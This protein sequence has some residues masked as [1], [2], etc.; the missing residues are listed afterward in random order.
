MFVADRKIK[1]CA[2]NTYGT[3]HD[4]NIAEYGIYEG[5]EQIHRE[6]WGKVVVGSTFGLQDQ[7]FLIRLSQQDTLN[8]GKLLAN[9]TAI[10]VRQLSK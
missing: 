7:E 4:N 8:A 2:L 6:S 10:L 3:F 9:R 1:L 5:L